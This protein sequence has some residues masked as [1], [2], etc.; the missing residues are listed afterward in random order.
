MKENLKEGDVVR[1]KSEDFN[2]MTIE[3]IGYI[4]TENEQANCIYFDREGKFCR[5][6][7]LTT[8]L[9]KD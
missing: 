3:N 2:K 5:Q 7:I 9:T 4:G 1:L 8:A 6:S